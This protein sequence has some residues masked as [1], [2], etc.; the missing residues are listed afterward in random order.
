MKFQNY[1]KQTTFRDNYADVERVTGMNAVADPDQLADPDKG[2][3]AGCIYWAG[4]GCNE[5]ADRDD[6]E[7]VTRKVNG[8][9]NG[10]DM[11]RAAVARAKTIFS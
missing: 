5:L 4:K 8:G 11:R 7:A 2:A 10:L 1:T 6:I 3:L 9:V